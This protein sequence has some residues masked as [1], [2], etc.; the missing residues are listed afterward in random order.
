MY[1]LLEKMAG[2]LKDDIQERSRQRRA[3]TSDEFE[4]IAT[5]IINALQ[6]LEKKRV[7]QR[8]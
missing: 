5:Q 1:I 4:K 2:T 7:W 3:F 8:H 6:H